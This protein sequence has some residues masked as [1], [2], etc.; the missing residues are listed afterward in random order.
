MPDLHSVL[1]GAGWGCKLM[2]RKKDWATIAAQNIW[3]DCLDRSGL[4]FEFRN[5]PADV[6]WNEII[7]TW[8]RNIRRAEAARSRDTEK[9]GAK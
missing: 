3:E 7:P 6:K 1:S 2:P 5:V 8:A 9:G 4:K